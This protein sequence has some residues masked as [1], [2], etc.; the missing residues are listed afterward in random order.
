MVVEVALDVFGSCP[1]YTRH[2]VGSDKKQ[3]NRNRLGSEAHVQTQSH[4]NAGRS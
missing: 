1:S 2:H 3:E 4:L